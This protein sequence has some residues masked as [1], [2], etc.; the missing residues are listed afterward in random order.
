MNSTSCNTRCGARSKRNNGTGCRSW[1]VRGKTRCRIH[2]GAFGSGAPL[3][4][5]NAL[6]HGLTTVEI[7]SF[8]RTVKIALREAAT[9][10]EELE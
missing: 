2:G 7:K 3:G 10:S 8:R 4:N 1:A 5:T 9:L 6:K